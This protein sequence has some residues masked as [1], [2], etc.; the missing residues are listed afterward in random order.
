LFSFDLPDDVQKAAAETVYNGRTKA[1][2][3]HMLSRPS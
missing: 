1:C 3:S 2:R